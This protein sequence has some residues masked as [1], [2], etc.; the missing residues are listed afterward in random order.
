MIKSLVS[1]A[2]GLLFA[3]VSEAATP[4]VVS[5]WELP[6]GAAESW[7]REHRI[8]DKTGT[9]FLSFEGQAPRYRY[10]KNGSVSV[11]GIKAGDFFL[12]SA[13]VPVLDAGTEVDASFYLSIDKA[14]GPEDW[15]CEYFDGKKWQVFGSFTLK[16]YENPNET[17]FV[18]TFPLRR[19]LKT[20]LLQVRARAL[21]DAGD[22]EARVS[23]MPSPRYGAYLAAWPKSNGRLRVLILGNS[24]TYHGASYLALT[25]I[26]HSQGKSLSIGIN[27]KGGQTFGQHLKLERSLAAIAEG[28]Y[29]AAILQNHAT[30]PCAYIKDPQKN[31]SVMEDSKALAAQVRQYSPSCRLI[32][33]LRWAMPKNDWYGY[34]SAEAFDAVLSEGT[35]RLA[36]GM[37]AE[38]APHGR[39][40]ALGRE[41]GLP[42]YW[43]DDAHPSVFGAYLKACVNYLVLFG[44]PFTED[45]SDYGLDPSKAAKC[46]KTASEIVLK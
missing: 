14:G 21:E 29:D 19:K 12:L 43:K 44:E 39:A 23:V 1:I 30:A 3:L 5:R 42:L 28:G 13:P 40:F 20:G 32:F 35:G 9:G 34:G 16:K 22:P 17:C 33:E 24:A 26:A 36:A 27:L 8:G 11:S 2:F 41:A 46:R 37:G 31:A 10:S 25:E 4:F 38:I 15:A 18:Q 7:T 45:A 6:A